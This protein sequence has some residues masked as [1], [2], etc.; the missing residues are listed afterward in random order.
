MQKKW[1]TIWVPYRVPDQTEQYCF[2]IG[3]LIL[4]Q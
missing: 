1:G 3:E 4:K 2:N